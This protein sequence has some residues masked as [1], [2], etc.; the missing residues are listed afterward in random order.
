MTLTIGIMVISAR[1]VH[2]PLRCGVAFSTEVGGALS[3]VDD[4]LGPFAV[5]SGSGAVRVLVVLRRSLIACY[6]NFVTCEW[7]SRSPYMT[8]GMSG[9]LWP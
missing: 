8:C 2:L 3:D 7:E 4:P 9:N 5:W 1:L 6:L